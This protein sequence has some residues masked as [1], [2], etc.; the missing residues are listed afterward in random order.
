[1]YL[2]S[3]FRDALRGLRCPNVSDGQTIALGSENCGLEAGQPTRCL[4]CHGSS[5]HPSPSPDEEARSLAVC[6][7]SSGVVTWRSSGRLRR[8]CRYR[9]R[10]PRHIRTQGHRQGACFRSRSL[11]L[12]SCHGITYGVADVRDRF[13]RCGPEKLAEVGYFGRRLVD[14]EPAE[15][16]N[17][18]SRCKKLKT[19]PSLVTISFCTSIVKGPRKRFGKKVGSGPFPLLPP[20]Y[21]GSVDELSEGCQPHQRCTKSTSVSACFPTTTTLPS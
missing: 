7:S 13:R 15:R 6:Y 9:C 20:S 21:H 11:G 1:M 4:C 19:C 17:K 14:C 10:V 5:V 3:R 18:E 8:R 2:I 16:R 12:R